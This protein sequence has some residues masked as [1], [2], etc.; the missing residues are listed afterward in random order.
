MKYEFEVDMI[1]ERWENISKKT[2]VLDVAKSTEE[3]KMLAL[4]LEDKRLRTW[5]DTHNQYDLIYRPVVKELHYKCYLHC[6]ELA[7]KIEVGRDE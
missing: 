2:K 5:W 3:R 4:L 6:L 7:S 1:H